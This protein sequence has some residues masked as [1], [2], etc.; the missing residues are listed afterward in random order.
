M[1]A[2]LIAACTRSLTVWAL[3]R[4]ATTLLPVETG[5]KTGPELMTAIS[6]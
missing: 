3:R 2:R 6:A 4:R 5:R 1:P